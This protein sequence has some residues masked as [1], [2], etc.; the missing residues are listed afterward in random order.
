[1]FRADDLAHQHGPGCP[2]ATEP[3]PHEGAQYEQLGIGLG[4][5]AEERKD[6]EPQYGDLECSNSPETIGEHAGKPA[7][8]RRSQQSH[9]SNQ[10]GIRVCDGEG[11]NNGWNC[12]AENLKL[13]RLVGERRDR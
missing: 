9:R 5:A 2:L 4:K 7:T 3:E 1:V 11:G 6:R 13:A 10:P 12:E 8:H